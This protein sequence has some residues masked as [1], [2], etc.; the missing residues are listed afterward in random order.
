MFMPKSLESDHC[1]LNQD[2]SFL[3]SPR[4]P[5]SL[6]LFTFSNASRSTPD[7][8]SEAAVLG[9]GPRPSLQVRSSHGDTWSWSSPSLPG[10]QVPS[11][12][13]GVCLQ[14]VGMYTLDHY[15]QEKDAC[16]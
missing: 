12:E 14:T 15:F 8:L 7:Y 6:L 3:V 2:F 1:T 9:R 16:R 10:L 11:A 5:S 13:K 4:L